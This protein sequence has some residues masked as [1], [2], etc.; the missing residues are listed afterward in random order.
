MSRLALLTHACRSGD[1]AEFLRLVNEEHA[2]PFLKIGGGSTLLHLAA[3]L[4]NLPVVRFYLEAKPLGL[5]IDVR[6]AVALGS[7]TPLHHAVSN[8]HVSAAEMLL[9]HGADPNLAEG[10]FR[11]TCLHLALRRGDIRMAK[12]LL[13]RSACDPHIRDCFGNNAFYWAREYGAL[14]ELKRSVPPGIRSLCCP[15][16]PTIEEKHV[17]FFKNRR[18][19]GIPASH[20]K[21]SHKLLQGSNKGKKKKKKKKKK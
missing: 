21:L 19:K 2:D 8:G 6:E 12:V 4:G 20:L 3:S 15:K 17:A 1:A 18:A 9:R 7:R 16:G 11:F 14:A 5:H 13:C 10:D